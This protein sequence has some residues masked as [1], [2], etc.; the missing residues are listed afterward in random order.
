MGKKV[1]MNVTEDERD[2]IINSLLEW[3]NSLISSGRH[4]DPID[5]LL[6]KLLKERL[7]S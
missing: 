2:L 4:T 6:Y 5:Q 7:K 1:K 3:K